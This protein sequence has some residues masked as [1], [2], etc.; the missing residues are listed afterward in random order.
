MRNPFRKTVIVEKFVEK[1][2]EV[3]KLVTQ[4][5]LGTPEPVKLY[6]ADTQTFAGP[7]PKYYHSC[8]Q[9]LADNPGATVRE[10][11][12]WKVGDIFLTGLRVTPVQVEPKPKRGKGK[13]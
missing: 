5:V 9:A 7:F 8:A 1:F 6:R 13:Q 2:V 12:L 11:S 4:T 3:P 10:V